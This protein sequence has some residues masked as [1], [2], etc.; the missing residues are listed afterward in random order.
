MQFEWDEEKRQANLQKHDVDFRDV[1]SVFQGPHL[2]YSSPVAK[3]K[4]RVAIGRL[5]RPE[6]PEG[7][8]GPLVAVVFVK[9]EDTYRI[10]SARRARDNERQAYQNLLG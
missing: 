10:I 6:R 7:W 5:R 4:R 3:E 8:S 9:R 2:T 1:G